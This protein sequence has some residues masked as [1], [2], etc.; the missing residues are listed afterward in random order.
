MSRGKVTVAERIEA[1]KACAEG[2]MSQTEAAHRLGVDRTSIQGWVA[3]YKAGGA[4]AFKEQAHNT[5][6]AEELKTAAVKEYLNSKKPLTT[7]VISSFAISA[8]SV[9]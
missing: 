9:F 2:R 6:Y 5:V 7:K 1:A 8:F 4:S 3:R